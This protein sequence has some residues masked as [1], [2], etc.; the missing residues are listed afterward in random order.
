MHV[1]KQFSFIAYLQWTKRE[2]LALA[3]LA[4]IPTLL[5][6][7]FHL[8][9]TAL[10]LF[11]ATI[12]GTTVAFV[13]AFKNNAAGARLYEAQRLYADVESA[14]ALFGMDVK[15]LLNP[16]TEAEFK[17]YVPRLINQHVAWLTTLRYQLRKEK[18]WDNLS[19]GGNRDFAHY[20]RIFEREMTLEAALQP[21][22]SPEEILTLM[23][24]HNPPT[25]CLQLQME[26]LK[27]LMEKGLIHSKAFY[28]VVSTLNKLN[29]VQINCL[30]VKNSPY[31]R[32]F[33]S[34]TKYL[35]ITFLIFLPYSL[36]GEFNKVGHVWLTI[37]VSMLIS[38]VYICLEKVGQSTTNPFEGGL[39]DVPITSISRG[40]EIELR[41]M[42]DQHDVPEEIKPMN[43]ILL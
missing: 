43:D 21:Y 23:S 1:G 17:P 25:Y 31:P 34:I 18:P 35:L 11:V 10:P 22:L 14:S 16:E 41:Q 5:H 20:Y 15:C 30:R 32:N 12:L 37:P 19:E 2:I 3:L 4:L 39:S 7:V 42:L 13:I 29:I 24:R 33:Y 28:H 38:W 26:L 36:V 6:S 27:A 40:I 8:T 9:F